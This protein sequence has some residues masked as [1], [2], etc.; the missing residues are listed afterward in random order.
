MDDRDRIAAGLLDLARTDDTITGAALTGSLATGDADRW[1][2]IDLA[3]AV[4]GDLAAPAGRWTRRLYEEFG[5][6]HHWDLP[7]DD[8]IIRIFLLP[9][10]YEADLN[11]TPEER[12]GARG[13]QWRTLFG[14]ELP[15][16][17]FPPP[18]TRALAGRAWHHALH[19]RNCL[20]RRHW[21]QCE[22]WIGSLR[23]VVITLACLRLGL[24]A[25]NGRGA[26]LLPAATAAALEPALVRSLTEPELRRALEAA[27]TALTG[28]LEQTDPALAAR[29]GPTLAGLVGRAAA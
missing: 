1:S 11:F 3:L 19:A 16:A 21:W 9:G 22:H 7:S 14:R 8:R 27:V 24:P 17:P 5:A 23:A 29:L 28:E 2:D 20:E 25:A 18:D 12:F 15:Q 10:P 26:H 13:P 4:R 6:L